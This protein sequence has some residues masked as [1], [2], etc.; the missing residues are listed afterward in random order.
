MD[1]DVS[2][3]P[4]EPH[5]EVRARMDRRNG[6]NLYSVEDAED[7]ELPFLGKVRGVREEGE[8]NM[9]GLKPKRGQE[10]RRAEG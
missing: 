2:P 6:G 1:T 3:V 7:V 10:D 8:G 5:H 4:L 9:H